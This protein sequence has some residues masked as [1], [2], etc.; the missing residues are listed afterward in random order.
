MSETKI[1]FVD[2]RSILQHPIQPLGHDSKGTVRFKQNAIVNFL[3]DH[4]SEDLNQLHIKGFSNEDWEQFS[5]LTGYSLSG[6]G[7][8][9]Y[10]TDRVYETARNVF[11]L[12]QKAKD[13]KKSKE[14]KS[15]IPISEPDLIVECDRIKIGYSRKD[16]DPGNE[17]FEEY[18]HNKHE[19]QEDNY[20]V[21]MSLR[22]VE[23][24]GLLTQI[25]KKLGKDQVQIWLNE[26]G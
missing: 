19:N 9:S 21:H 25:V 10:V 12:R 18:S 26:Q 14:G 1:E 15:I 5:Q 23:V 8:L 7:D 11:D 2:E 3:K 17:D 24:E 6:F 22:G 20:A 16:D 13:G 4:S